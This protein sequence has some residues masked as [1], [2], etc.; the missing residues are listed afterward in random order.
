MTYFSPVNRVAG[1]VSGLETQKIVEDLMKIAR[2]PLDR[3]VQERK[4]LEWRQEDYRA[5]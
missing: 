5:I 3:I 4:I 2:I 1:L